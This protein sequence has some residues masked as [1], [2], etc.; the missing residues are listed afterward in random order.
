MFIGIYSSLLAAVREF[1]YYY[2][3]NEFITFKRYINISAIYIYCNRTIN[4]KKILNQGSGKVR[5]IPLQAWTSPEDSRRLRLSDF[6]TTGR[7]YPQE[8]FLAIRP[9]QN[10]LVV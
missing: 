8:I 5:A 10:K 6:K 7:L 2:F 3:F 4:K 1:Y 9:T